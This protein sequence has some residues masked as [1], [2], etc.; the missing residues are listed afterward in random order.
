MRLWPKSPLWPLSG[1]FNADVISRLS[2]VCPVPEPIPPFPWGIW[3]ICEAICDPLWL[4]LTPFVT[5]LA[6]LWRVPWSIFESLPG[7][8]GV[9][10]PRF[11]KCNVPLWLLCPLYFPID[12]L[13]VSPLSP[14]WALFSLAQGWG[15]SE[16]FRHMLFFNADG[17]PV[18][19]PSIAFWSIWNPF[20][21]KWLHF[22]LTDSIDQ[23]ARIRL[24][25]VNI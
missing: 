4:T 23:S 24:F 17:Q 20:K 5:G 21:L 6:G 18:Y 10:M 16:A 12:H 9:F 2:S 15:I 3:G 13:N 19:W 11:K 1:P 7:T 14:L 25:L 22:L 8:F